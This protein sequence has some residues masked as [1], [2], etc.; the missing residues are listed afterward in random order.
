MVNVK[1]NVSLLILHLII[2]LIL[3]IIKIIIDFFLRLFGVFVVNLNFEIK[4]VK[5]KKIKYSK[6]S[7][8]IKNE[9]FF[10]IILK[11]DTI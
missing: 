1:S 5:I 7:I 11:I 9:L 2:L 10:N 4:M 3:K 6:N 8:Y